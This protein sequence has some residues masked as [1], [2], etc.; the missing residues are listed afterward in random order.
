MTNAMVH[1]TAY[2]VRTYTDIPFRLQVRFSYNVR[3]DLMHDES[4][5]LWPNKPIPKTWTS[6]SSSTMLRTNHSYWRVSTNEAVS[7][8]ATN[9]TL[10]LLHFEKTK[11]I[12]LSLVSLAEM[13][14]ACLSFPLRRQQEG[15][16]NK[17]GVYTGSRTLCMCTCD[18]C[19]TSRRQVS[20]PEFT[21]QKLF[22]N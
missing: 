3:Q 10:S 9:I 16:Y 13:M 21:Y 5:C 14:T 15:L 7:Q 4:P 19:V 1:T 8:L 11:R 6:S 2:S 20:L 17:E 22:L 12:E 18:R